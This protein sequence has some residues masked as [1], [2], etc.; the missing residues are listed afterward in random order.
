M[1]R[2][3][4][5]YLKKFLLGCAILFLLLLSPIGDLVGRIINQ[6]FAALDSRFVNNKT[7]SIDKIECEIL[8]GSMALVGRILY[9][10]ASEI[11]EHYLNGSG[12]DLRIDAEYLKTS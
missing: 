4:M 1:V 7:N 5:I 10:E 6:H 2:S 12:S 8:Y 11:L 3:S 9:P